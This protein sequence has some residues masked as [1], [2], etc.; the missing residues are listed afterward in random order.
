MKVHVS[1]TGE[2]NQEYAYMIALLLYSLRKNGGELSDASVTVT[3]NGAEMAEIER[4]EIERFQPVTCRVLPRQ[5]AGGGFVNKFNALYAPEKNYDV[6]LFLDCDTVVLKPL[7][8]LVSGMNPEKAQFRGRRIGKPGAQSVGP[9][10]PLIREY[11]LP[12]GGALDDVAD[13]RFP[14][15]YPMFNSGVMAMTQPA[16]KLIRRDGSRIAYQ[17]YAERAQT[18]KAS[19]WEMLKEAARRAEARLFPKVSQGTYDFW[20]TEQLGFAFSLLKNEIDYDVL[21]RRFN[22]VHPEG[23]RDEDLPAV[24][25]YMAGRHPQIDRSHLFDGDWIDDYLRGDSPPRKAFA[26]LVWKYASVR[27]SRI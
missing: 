5:H 22:W 3:T 7:D 24:F 2:P 15:G 11:A 14:L 20:V 1:V 4:E 13:D 26:Q 21:P 10:E 6:L 12:E 9:A 17:L 23:P 25:H 16:V 19:V 27:R 8:E 18:S